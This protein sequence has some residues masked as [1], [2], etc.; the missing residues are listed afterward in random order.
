M[1][2]QEVLVRVVRRDGVLVAGPDALSW[3]QGQVSQDVEQML[4]GETRHSLVLSPEG[5]VVSLC[6]VTLLGGEQAQ[7]DVEEGRGGELAER[8]SRFT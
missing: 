1:A 5:K 6:R 8:L 4:D 7:L 3:L 2:E